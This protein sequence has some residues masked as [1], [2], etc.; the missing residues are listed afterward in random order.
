MAAEMRVE[1]RRPRDEG[2]A[3]AVVDHGEAAGA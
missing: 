2:R 3:E 1:R